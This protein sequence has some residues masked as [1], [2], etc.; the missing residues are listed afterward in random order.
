[1]LLW[2]GIL[3]LLTLA[4][5]ILS[6]FQTAV[7]YSKLKEDAVY[8]SISDVHQCI[9]AAGSSNLPDLISSKFS[10][11]NIIFVDCNCKAWYF[12]TSFGYCYFFVLC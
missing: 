11:F 3:A 10:D 2:L 5:N 9:D 7:F 1:V 6:L 8:T 12:S 4:G